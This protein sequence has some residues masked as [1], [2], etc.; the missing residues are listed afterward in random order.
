M[1]RIEKEVTWTVF[2][3]LTRY[4]PGTPDEHYP[5]RCGLSDS[6]VRVTISDALTG[7]KVLDVTD[8]M[9][10]GDLEEWAHE[11]EDME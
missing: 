8:F 5:D 1:N 3:E 10:P 7:G 2:V 6:G 4:A 9:D 11:L